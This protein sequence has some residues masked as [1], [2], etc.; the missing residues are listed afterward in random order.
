MNFLKKEAF[1][2]LLDAKINIDN[3]NYSMQNDDD[4][5]P[6]LRNLRAAIYC[7]TLTMNELENA[8]LINQ[9]K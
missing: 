1:T 5:F 8:H 3:C 2:H 7:I 4:V 6:A 9:K